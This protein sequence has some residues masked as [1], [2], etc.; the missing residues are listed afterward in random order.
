MCR[1]FTEEHILEVI[2]VTGLNNLI[3]TLQMGLGTTP[4]IEPRRVFGLQDAHL[5]PSGE[6]QTDS[7]SGLG[8]GLA[9]EPLVDA[10]GATTLR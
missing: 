10:V 1:G 2:A 8:V 9:E 5:L 6:H 4:D 7:L 3:N